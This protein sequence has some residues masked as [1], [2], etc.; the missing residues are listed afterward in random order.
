MW[1]KCFFFVLLLLSL[2]Y[3]FVADA[4]LVPFPPNFYVTIGT[5]IPFPLSTPVAQSGAIYLS[6]QTR[7]LRI[8]NFFLGSQYSFIADGIRRRGYI[9]E[10]HAPGS[11]G[12]QNEGKRSFC[13]TFEMAGDVSTFGVPEGFVKHAEKN[14]VRGVE[15]VGYTG[16]DRDS[17]GPMQ[18]VE[19]YVRNVTFRLPGR[20]KGTTEDVV[21]TIPWRIQ[22]RRQQ[23]ALKELTDSPVTVPNWRYF[24]GPFFD[25]VVMPDEPFTNELERLMGD[26]TVTVDFYNFV[27]IVPDP[28]VF[29]VPSDCEEAVAEP[30]SNVDITLAQRL[31]VD[32]SFYTTAG[33]QVLGEKSQAL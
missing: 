15:V 26:T 23:Q 17:S 20:V 22:T 29:S 2:T 28:S 27:P 14:L 5:T 18:Q 7:Q 24:G 6:N 4:V 19:Y 16:Y 25:E 11:F 12:E 32:L 31:L 33:R 1:P 30:T 9:L 13:R 3:T 21:F 8:D 10:T